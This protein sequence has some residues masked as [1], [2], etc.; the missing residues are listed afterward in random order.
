MLAA[1]RM[2]IDR[3]RRTRG[4][5]FS[6]TFNRANS[7]TTIN[8]ASDGGTWTTDGAVWGISSNAATLISRT[9]TGSR[10]TVRRDLGSAA[11]DVTFV[12]IRP[13]TNGSSFMFFSFDPV[14]GAG[15]SMFY[16]SS[17]NVTLSLQSS[18]SSAGVLPGA[19]PVPGI[20]SW[21]GG[22]TTLR[23]TCDG[24]RHISIYQNGVLKASITDTIAVT[25]PAGTW[26]GF[27]EGSSSTTNLIDSVTA[28]P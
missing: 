4:V 21:T 22:S 1:R 6:D 18:F 8:P 12:S 27:D 14:T 11:C 19:H 15:Y 7:T 20:A 3:A 2:M 25:P 23:V 13:T 28:I 24:N 9:A 16:D 26:V 10:A 17:G 5:P